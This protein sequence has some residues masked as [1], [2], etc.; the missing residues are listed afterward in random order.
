MTRSPLRTPPAAVAVASRFRGAGWA[1]VGVGVAAQICYPLTSGTARDGLTAVSIAAFGLAAVVAACPRPHRRR[2]AA[3]LA[4]G[5]LLCWA[6]EVTG[7]RTGLPFGHYRYAGGLGPTP[8]GV[9]LLVPSAWIAMGVPCLAASRRLA[10]TSTRWV[11]ALV[12]GGMLASWDLFLDPQMVTDGHWSWHDSG[13]VLAGSHGIPLLNF[14]G[15]LLTGIMLI[16][17]LDAIPG[18]ISA[19]AEVIVCWTYF[20]EVL[21]NLAFFHRPSVAGIGAV[22]MGIFVIPYLMTRYRTT[23]YGSRGAR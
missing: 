16:A 1:A 4:A 3:V 2:A 23:S 14:L 18:P 19:A 21:A 11:R 8:G 6:L 9:P 5:W 13:P 10:A 12:G 17:L 20:S 7:V 15:W 22:G